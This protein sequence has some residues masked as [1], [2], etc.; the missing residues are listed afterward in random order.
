ML[1]E[2]NVEFESVTKVDY[3]SL[4]LSLYFFLLIF[5]VL[6]NYIKP[7]F[8]QNE[9]NV[10]PS[11]ATNTSELPDNLLIKDPRQAML[12]EANKFYKT[13]LLNIIPAN[14]TVNNNF[15]DILLQI[16]TDTYSFFKPQSSAVNISEQIFLSNLAAIL[17]QMV[18]HYGLNV[19]VEL[20]VK[21]MS[22]LNEELS[23]NLER[24]AMIGQYLVDSGVL[25]HK[26]ETKISPHAHNILAFSL[27]LKVY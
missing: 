27:K 10:L 16:N 7:D 5:F 17:Q 11:K 25:A 8:S 15:H 12:Y 14:F 13:K 9:H 20:G 19:V 2:K 6:L 24:A 22:K 26:I 23:L 4:Q 3:S 21:D 18:Q 1:E